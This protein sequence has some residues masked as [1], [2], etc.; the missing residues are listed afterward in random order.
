[1]LPPYI[2]QSPPE[3]DACEAFSLCNYIFCNTGWLPSMVDLARISDLSNPNNERASVVLAAA[4]NTGLTAY[5]N[6]P[7]PVPFTIPAFYGNPSNVPR[8]KLNLTL[9][10]PASTDAYLWTQLQ[11][12]SNLAQPTNHMVVMIN[13]GSGNFID[14]ESGGQIKNINKPTIFGGPPAKIIWQ[15][16][17]TINNLPMNPIYLQEGSSTLY[18]G[19]GS[20]LIPFSTDYALYQQNFGQNPVIT[21]TAAQFA[22][23]SVATGIA[24][25]SL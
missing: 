3:S 22:Q 9:R 20:V 17:I 5:A 1:M 21:L 25:K 14:S 7:L 13:D 19:V 16:A 8:I 11:W 4:N 6:C 23:F 2:L 10:P 24:V 15:S 18:F 12:G